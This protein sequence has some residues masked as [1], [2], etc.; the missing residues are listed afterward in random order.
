MPSSF[1]RLPFDSQMKGRAC[2]SCGIGPS[3]TQIAFTSDSLTNRPKALPI[4]LKTLNDSSTNSFQASIRTCVSSTNWPWVACSSISGMY[5][6]QS[7]PSSTT[8]VNMQLRACTTIKYR[9][10]DNGHPYQ[11]DLWSWKGLVVL[12]C[13]RMQV[14]ADAFIA[15]RRPIKFGPKPKWVKSLCRKSQLMQSNAFMVSNLRR[16]NSLPELRA[17]C[18]SSLSSISVV[19]VDLPGK[20][21]FCCSKMKFWSTLLRQS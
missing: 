4:N 14:V 21:A 5:T 9:R 17:L 1:E 7:F 16:M 18:K 8:L 13:S 3:A 19:C 11:I 10:G 2:S 12:P 15:L 6:P 20:K